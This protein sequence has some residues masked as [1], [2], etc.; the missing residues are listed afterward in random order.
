MNKIQF[1]ECHFM[2][3]HNILKNELGYKNTEKRSTSWKVSDPFI[4][5]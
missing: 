4:T 5:S 1:N 2:K 3:L